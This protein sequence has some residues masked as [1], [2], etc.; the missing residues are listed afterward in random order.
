[1]LNSVHALVI[2]NGFIDFRDIGKLHGKTQT[3]VQVGET[4]FTQVVR[5]VVMLF[6]DE[7]FKEISN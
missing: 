6:K 2:V 5:S 3:G 1:M 7:I 4:E